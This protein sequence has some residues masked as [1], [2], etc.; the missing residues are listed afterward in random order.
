MKNM[1]DNQTKT[2]LHVTYINRIV[3][4]HFSNIQKKNKCSAYETKYALFTF[5][6]HN[7]MRKDQ[8]E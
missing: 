8:S 4:S 1:H 2:G 6:K 5:L 7:T 3:I